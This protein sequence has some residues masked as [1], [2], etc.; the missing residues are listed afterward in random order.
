[1]LSKCANPSCAA[2]FRYLHEGKL[3]RFETDSEAKLGQVEKHKRRIEYYWLCSAC[4]SA[5]SL[6]YDGTNG[7]RTVPILFLRAAS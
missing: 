6:R 1:M 3:F 2:R 7:L 5:M 4:C